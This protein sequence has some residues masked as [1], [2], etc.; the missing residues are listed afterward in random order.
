MIYLLLGTNLGCKRANLCKARKLL[1][2]ALNTD[3]VKTKVLK[4]KAIGFDGPS[5]LNQVIAF[6]ASDSLT[7]EF[8]LDLCQKVEREM[9]RPPHKAEYDAEGCRV[10]ESRVIDIDILMFEDLAIDTERLKIPHP[11]VTERPFVK[12]LLNQIIK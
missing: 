5:F 7:P 12:E 6:S 10:Y 9:G 4:T 1:K 2:K 11:Q 8:L 3:F